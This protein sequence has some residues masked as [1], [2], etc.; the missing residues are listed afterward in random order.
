MKLTR[1]LFLCSCHTVVRPVSELLTGCP[2]APDFSVNSEVNSTGEDG[3]SNYI[4]LECL[5]QNSRIHELLAEPFL[6]HVSL[7]LWLLSM[8]VNFWLE[9]GMCLTVVT[10]ETR[11]RL[12]FDHCA[13]RLIKYAVS[14]CFWIWRIPLHQGGHTHTNISALYTYNMLGFFKSADW[15]NGNTWDSESVWFRIDHKLTLLPAPWLWARYLA[16]LSR[17][18]TRVVW[19]RHLGVKFKEASTNL[20][21]PLQFAP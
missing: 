18:R 2:V 8:C 10:F 19:A 21:A 1:S 11:R 5:R 12:I 13:C 14:L 4:S 15:Y 6:G 7:T 17:A 9:P 3:M 20:R 16:S